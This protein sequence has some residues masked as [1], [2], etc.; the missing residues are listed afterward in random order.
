MN[1]IFV[2]MKNL[3]GQKYVNSYCYTYYFSLWEQVVYKY[4]VIIVIYE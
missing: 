2:N 1:V 3:M 4:I